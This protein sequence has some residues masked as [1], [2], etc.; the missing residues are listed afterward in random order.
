MEVVATERR[1]GTSAGL[2]KYRMSSEIDICRRI[3]DGGFRLIPRFLVVVRGGCHQLLCDWPDDP[4][5]QK[6][7]FLWLQALF[8]WWNVSEFTCASR[9][10]DPDAVVFAYV[11]A[12]VTLY[13]KLRVEA[14]VCEKGEPAFVS[15]Q[16]ANPLINLLGNSSKNLE[17]GRV[18]QVN[19]LLGCVPDRSI[20]VLSFRASTPELVGRH[21]DCFEANS[22]PHALGA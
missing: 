10:R 11:S 3:V 2:L 8:S 9:V 19:S 6:E 17:I 18:L 14:G 21:R 16:I 5:A 4:A 22:A 15:N 20:Y 13:A 12:G 1:F 7:A